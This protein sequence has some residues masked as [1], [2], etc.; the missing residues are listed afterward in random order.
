MITLRSQ[1]WRER[2]ARFVPN[3]S[4]IDTDRY[5]VDVIS[6]R[7]AKS[8]VVKHHYAGTMPATRL[9]TG[10]FGPGKGGRPELCGVAVFSVPVNNKSVPKTAGLD[11]PLQAVD[12]GR[13]VL[14]DSVGGNA[15]SWTIRQAFRHLRREK[16]DVI[17]VISYSDPVIRRDARGNLVLPGH[18]GSAYVACSAR[19]SGRSS[20]RT[21]F[22]MPNGRL[23]SPRAISKI[24]NDETGAAYAVRQIVDAGAPKP[25]GDLRKW[26]SGLEDSGLLQR[27]RHPGNH[28]YLFPLTRA[29]RLA[30]RKTPQEP[31]PVLDR[32]ANDG[33]VT[34]LPL[35]AA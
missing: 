5:S 21:D 8:F 24:R 6:D 16:P 15:E 2:R 4:V 17:S 18:V 33:D 32:A 12:L 28:T 10:L 7:L 20:P 26:L 22:L 30:A 9:C 35:L 34:H 23:L 25:N 1:R 11:D 27:R 31:Y 19:Y 29:A 3:A 13:L 14:L